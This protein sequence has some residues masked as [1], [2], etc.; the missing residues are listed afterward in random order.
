VPNPWT[1]AKFVTHIPQNFLPFQKLLALVMYSANSMQQ[2]DTKTLELEVVCL[3]A[4][5]HLPHD[6]LCIA[7][8]ARVLCLDEWAQALDKL[9]HEHA[10][11]CLEH[12]LVLMVI[13]VKLGML[14]G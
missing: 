14:L 10:H 11:A 1:R 2:L 9:L 6:C 5:V 3:V 7:W 13:Y 8:C 12:V 4:H